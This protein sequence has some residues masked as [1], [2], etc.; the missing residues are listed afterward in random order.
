MR[1]FALLPISLAFLLAVTLGVF[2][3][4]R[5]T[6]LTLEKAFKQVGIKQQQIIFSGQFMLD[7]Q[8]YHCSGMKNQLNNLATVLSLHNVDSSFNANPF[9]ESGQLIGYLADQSKVVLK[10]DSWYYSLDK[11]VKKGTKLRFELY[12]KEMGKEEKK[13]LAKMKKIAKNR[14]KE[15]LIST[16]LL[17]TIHGKLDEGQKRSWRKKIFQAA[18]AEEYKEISYNQMSTFLGYTPW[19]LQNMFSQG[20]RTNFQLVIRYSKQANSTIILLGSPIIDLDY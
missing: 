19:I 3:Y 9:G 13:F 17:G 16:C 15:L 18:D 4:P 5:S 11:Q 10:G 2:F 14:H 20:Q 6:W 12:S 7:N 8:N 1:R